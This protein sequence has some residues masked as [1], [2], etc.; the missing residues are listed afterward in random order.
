M[1]RRQG[2]LP[3]D[4]PQQL[5]GEP[6]MPAGPRRQAANA[7][8]H[9]PVLAEHLPRRRARHVPRAD[10]AH[11]GRPGRAAA[12]G[13][14]TGGGVM[15]KPSARN[16]TI[17]R[18]WTVLHLITERPRTLDELACELSVTTRTIRRDIEALEEAAF[19]LYNERDDDGAVRWHTLNPKATP[20]RAA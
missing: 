8:G 5:A 6:Q 12:G 18:T 2:V 20:Q 10:L 19:P 9:R 13:A 3:F 16:R 17:V 11:A 15:A 4:P 14:G 7:R 1:V